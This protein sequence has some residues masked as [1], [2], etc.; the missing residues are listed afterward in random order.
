VKK[1]RIKK[2]LWQSRVARMQRL[3][4]L[5]APVGIIVAE[6]LLLLDGVGIIPALIFHF[7]LRYWSR[8][9]YARLMLWHRTILRKSEKEIE[10]MFSGE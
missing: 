4:A 3:C 7:R 10:A 6:A 5:D 9:D 8:I 1:L 2:E